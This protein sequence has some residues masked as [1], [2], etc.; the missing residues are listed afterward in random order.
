MAIRIQRCTAETAEGFRRALDAV[1]R[2]RRHLAY[3]QAPPPE[4]MRRF[5]EQ[6]LAKGWSQFYALD[7]NRVVGWCDILPDERE[8]QT[9]CGRLGM[10]LLPEYRGRGIGARLI[11]ATLAD[12]LGKGLT[13]I[14]LEVFA[15][16]TRAR[17]LY[18]KAGFAE[19]GRKRRARILDGVAD[20]IVIMALLPPPGR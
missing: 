7:E 19:E 14:E 3:L 4:T 18:R 1:A 2:E 9:H 13:R 10:G 12:A 16:N 8:G 20:D 15:S 11:S 5:V 17:A 6:I